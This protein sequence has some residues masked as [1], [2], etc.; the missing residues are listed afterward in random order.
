VGGA[1]GSPRKWLKRQNL[2]QPPLNPKYNP[3]KYGYVGH[4]QNKSC[5]IDY[6][7]LIY[8]LFGGFLMM[9]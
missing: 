8:K 9:V 2:D 1:L 7:V 3:L 6:V 4:L 5:E